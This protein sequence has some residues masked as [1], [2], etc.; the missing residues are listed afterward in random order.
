LKCPSENQIRAKFFLRLGWSIDILC[1]GI[2]GRNDLEVRRKSH[3]CQFGREDF[4]KTFAVHPIVWSSASHAERQ[5]DEILS[6]WQ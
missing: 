6:R 3:L 2:T 1:T 5:D 4:D